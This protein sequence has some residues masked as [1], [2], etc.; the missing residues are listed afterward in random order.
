MFAVVLTAV[1]TFSPGTLRDLEDELTVLP[2]GSVQLTCQERL[3]EPGDM[4]EK[5]VLVLLATDELVDSFSGIGFAG[6]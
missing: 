5:V 6:G 4:D 1:V 2:A 3:P